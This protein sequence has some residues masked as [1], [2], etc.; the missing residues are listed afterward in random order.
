MNIGTALLIVK[1]YNAAVQVHGQAWAD[2]NCLALGTTRY[3]R[4]IAALRHANAVIKRT[5]PGLA[6]TDQREAQK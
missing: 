6:G 4:N 3:K 5:K 2:R 1:S